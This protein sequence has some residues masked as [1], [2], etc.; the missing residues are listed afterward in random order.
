MMHT[1]GH[2]IGGAQSES[3]GAA[4]FRSRNPLTGLEWGQFASG[5]AADVDRAVMAAD[6]AFD[7]WRR[8]SAS[9][10]GKLLIRWAEGLRANAARIGTLESTQNGKL[11]RESVGQA[12]ALPDWLYYYAGLADKIEGEVIPLERPE[13]VNYTTHEP[14]GVVAIITPWNSPSMLTMFAA[15]PALAAGNTIV[16]KPSEVTSA[17]LIELARIAGSVGIPPGVINVV[18][19]LRE[20]AEHLVDHP[21]VV[22]IAFTGSVEGGRAVAERAARRLVGVTLE[23]GGKSPQIVF[24]DADLK[25][26]R[27]GILTGIFSSTGQT[28]V[29]GSRLYVHREIYDE[30][31]DGLVARAVKIRVGDPMSADT[32]MGPVATLAQ[33]EKNQRLTDEAVARGATVLCGGKRMELAEHPGGYFFQ[34]TIL[35][36]LSRDNPILGQE[37]FGPVLAV[38]PFDDEEEALELANDSQFG[39]AAG[40]WTLDFRRAHRMARAVQAGTVWVNMYRTLGC[41]SPVN[42]F[43]QSGLGSQNGQAAIFQY[44]Q[45]KSIWNNFSD[46][47]EDPFPD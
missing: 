7:S 28:C 17:S 13:V 1:F 46:R 36:N 12:G 34:P 27:A 42:G 47:I 26:A 21:K 37:V 6:A 5:S 38:L 39:L 29:A 43:K 14:M 11:L 25:Q 24:P 41:N 18:T 22:K 3:A 40:V 10:R 44:L 19:G 9:A 4:Q 33:L 8:M 2:H 35:S 20:T 15:A 30:F 31:L 23:L 16:I 45:T 32:Q